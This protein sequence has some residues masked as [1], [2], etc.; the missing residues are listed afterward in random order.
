MLSY[1]SKVLNSW[2]PGDVFPYSTQ[3]LG[4]ISWR[5]KKRFFEKFQKVFFLKICFFK[6]PDQV[7]YDLEAWLGCGKAFPGFQEFKKKKEN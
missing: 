6:R 4:H 3:F 7:L 2:K 5:L 1:P